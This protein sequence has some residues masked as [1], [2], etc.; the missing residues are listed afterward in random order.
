M[1]RM[2]IDD[3]L[4]SC[5]EKV[6]LRPK[7]YHGKNER[8]FMEVICGMLRPGDGWRDLP[9]TMVTGKVVKIVIAM[10]QKKLIYRKISGI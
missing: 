3:A 1:S 4:W 6:L 2:V 9:A 5:L 8:L 7:G 10:G